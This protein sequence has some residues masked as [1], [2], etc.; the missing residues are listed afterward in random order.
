LC[1][2]TPFDAN[3]QAEEIQNILKAKFA[4]EPK[5]YWEDVSEE[6]ES[7]FRREE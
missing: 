4:F 5:E 1:G 3:T 7:L 2:Y 6:G